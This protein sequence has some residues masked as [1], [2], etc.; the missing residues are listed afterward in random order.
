MNL[1]YSLMVKE[2]ID[3][4]LECRFIYL[5][6]HSEWISS[7][8]VVPKKKG[9]LRIC[10][11]FCKLNS[12]TKKD[13]FPLPFTSAILD[14]VVGHE[15]YSFVD[16]FSSYNQIQI[17]S[18]DRPFTTFTMDWDT[19]ACNIMPFGLC[20]VPTTIQRA[21]MSAFQHYL[22]KFIEIFLGDFCVFSSKASHVEC[23]N[24]CFE[25]CKEYGISINATKFE[26]VVPQRRL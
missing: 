3:I 14:G 23:F 13:Y 20:N 10:Q 17:T 4:L 25:Q 26:F 9:K 12:V 24:E 18:E 7:T 8:V 6:P 16:G 5:V 21:M 11:D 15:C 2:E 22:R 19:F 1:K